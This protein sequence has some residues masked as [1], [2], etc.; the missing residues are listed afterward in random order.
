[1]MFDPKF[2]T[3]PYGK[4][5]YA[6]QFT[7]GK[8]TEP[9]FVLSRIAFDENKGTLSYHYDIINDIVINE[10]DKEEFE[11]AIGDLLMYMIQEGLKRNDLVYT[12]GVDES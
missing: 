12:G 11:T 2:T 7:E 5:S 6:I 8:F 9:E 10:S 1:M 4:D 3:T